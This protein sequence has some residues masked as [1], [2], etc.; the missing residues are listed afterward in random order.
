MDLGPYTD[1]IPVDYPDKAQLVAADIQEHPQNIGVLICGTGEG[2]CMAV[3]KYSFIRAGLVYNEETAKMTRLH[4][5]ANVICLGGRTTPPESAIKYL[6]IFLNTSFEGG[7]H[8]RRIQK[9]GDL[10]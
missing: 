3:N 4:N 1:V 10:K 2:M 5:D 8:Q 7:R 6:D 9:L